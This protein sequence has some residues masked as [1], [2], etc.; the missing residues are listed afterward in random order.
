MNKFMLYMHYIYK[1][2]SANPHAS[3][4]PSNRRPSAGNDKF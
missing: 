3:S 4:D 2:K 1:M